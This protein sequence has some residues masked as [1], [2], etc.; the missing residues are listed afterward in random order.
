MPGAG[1]C[2]QPL[3]ALP[4]HKVPSVPAIIQEERLFSPGWLGWP[5]APARAVC[6]QVKV[7]LSP[8]GR[9]HHRKADVVNTES[10]PQ[11]EL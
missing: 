4:E 11:L 6:H 10:R 7:V 9:T 8:T 5:W 2:S 1:G 3:G